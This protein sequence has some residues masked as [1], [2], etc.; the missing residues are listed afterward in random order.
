M[1][2]ELREAIKKRKANQ[3]QFAQEQIVTKGKLIARDG[4]TSVQGLLNHVWVAPE[5]ENEPI[6]AY[7]RNVK[8]NRVGLGVIVGFAPS[9]TI[10]E[11]LRTDV[12]SVAGFVDTTGLDTQRHAPSHLIG[13]DD[14]HFI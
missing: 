5:G 10:L 2:I 1:T 4:S 14:P 13:G 3:A 8:D 7:N 11:I 6:A 9:S 12:E